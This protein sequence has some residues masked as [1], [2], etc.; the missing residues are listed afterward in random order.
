[1][2]VATVSVAALLIQAA[3]GA[4][5]TRGGVLISGRAADFAQADPGQSAG[6]D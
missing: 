6:V 5:L 1:L 4:E 3:F 2:I